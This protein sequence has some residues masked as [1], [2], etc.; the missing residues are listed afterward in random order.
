M[1]IWRSVNKKNH[2]SERSQNIV[3]IDFIQNIIPWRK[4]GGACMESNTC[5]ESLNKSKH[6]TRQKKMEGH[7]APPSPPR[8]RDAVYYVK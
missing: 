2:K 4:M 5:G 1:L 3:K 6:R 8:L 7:C